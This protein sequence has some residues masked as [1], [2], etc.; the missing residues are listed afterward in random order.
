MKKS[1]LSFMA[2]MFFVVTSSFAELAPQWVIDLHEP[3]T[4]D[5]M[6]YRLL[7]PLDFDSGRLYPVIVS[8]HG[9][10]GVGTENISNLREWNTTLSDPQLRA[11]Y[12]TYVVVPQVTNGLWSK[13]HLQK[14]KTIVAALPSVDMGRIYVLGQS[15]GGYGVNKMIQWDPGYFAAATPVAGSRG[16]GSADLVKNIPIWAFHGTEDTVSSFQ[17]SQDFFDEM[18]AI[19]GNMKFTP[20]IGW[21]HS[22]PDFIPFV[23]G[24]STRAPTYLSSDRCDPEPVYMTWLFN[25]IL[26]GW[27]PLEVNS[28]NGSGSYTNGQQVAISA[29]AV[30]GRTFVQWVGDT[31]VV[32]NVTYTNALVTMSNNAVTLTATYTNLPG[33]SMLTVNGGSGSAAYTNGTEAPITANPAPAG[34][35]FER[36]TGD[37]QVVES[38]TSPSTVVTMPVQDVFLTAVYK[39][40]YR[41]TVNNGSGSGTYTNGQPVEISANPGRTFVAWIGDTQVVSSATASPATVTMP[42]TGVT[43]TATYSDVILT[44]IG[45]A[46]SGAYTS[47]QTV[48]IDASD[49]RPG[50]SFK[51]WIGTGAPYVA[52]V[53]SASTTVT[54]PVQDIT[55]TATHYY[56]L[57]VNSG[58]G[59]GTYTNGQQV[60]I[61]A[62]TIPW[63]AFD[64]WTGD[65][66]VLDEVIY[67]D[68]TVTMSTNPVTLTATYVDSDRLIVLEWNSV[69]NVTAQVDI[70]Q[71]NRVIANGVYNF[72]GIYDGT[73]QAIL[74]PYAG[75]GDY[76]GTALYGV[77]QSDKSAF[78]QWRLQTASPFYEQKPGSGG[79]YSELLYLKAAD[80]LDM[81]T[82][83]YL[84]ELTVNNPA[85]YRAA[86]RDSG[87]GKWYVSDKS[88]TTAAGISI[89]NMAD[90]ANQWRELTITESSLM[91][92]TNNPIV[93]PSFTA[94]NAVGLF[95]DR[96]TLNIRPVLLRVTAVATYTITT[97]T[98]GL[99][100]ISPTSPTVLSGDS[101]AFVISGGT[102]GFR[103]AT[104][105]TN[106][107]DVA[108]LI[109][110]NS[111][112]VVNFT[113]N[114]VTADG[115]LAATF[116]NILSTLTVNNGTGGGGIYTNGQ[117]VVIEAS[118]A[119]AGMV[120]DRWDG[121]GAPYAAS[122]YAPTTTVTMGSQSISLTAMYIIPT[123]ALTVNSGS[124]GGSYTN[125]QQV[126]ISA[127]PVSGNAFVQ[128]IGDTQVVN[129]VTYTNA[130]VTMSTNPVTLTA[131]YTK[132]P[133][134]ATLTINNGTGGGAYTNETQVLITASNAPA[135]QAFD[136]WTGD[137]QVVASVTS[138]S[139]TVTM[140]AQDVSLTATYK[141]VY[142]LTVNGGTGSGVYTNGQLVAVGASDVRPGVSFRE[143]IGTGAP[144]VT[145]TN[146]ASTT[147]I[148][149]PQNITLIA[150]Y[151]YA[152][153]VNSG[154]GSGVYTNGEQVVIT[155]SN[156]PP[157]KVFRWVGD[158][159]VVNKVTYTNALVT[160]STNP[161]TLTATYVD[162]VPAT[163]TVVDSTGGETTSTALPISK[164]FSITGGNVLVV[165]LS[166]KA[167][168]NTYPAGPAD[169]YWVTSGGTVTQT[170]TRAV[171]AGN[172][173]A[174]AFGSSIFYLWNPTAGSGTISGSLPAGYLAQI[175]SA[176]T[177]SGVDTSVL[178]IIASGNAG[179]VLTLSSVTTT[180]VLTGVPNGGFAALC[181]GS[182]ATNSGSGFSASA[183]GGTPVNWLSPYVQGYW[184]QGYISNLVTTTTNFT[185][186]HGS[187]AR[188]HIVAA[189]F[190]PANITSLTPAV[191][192]PTATGITTTNATLGATVIPNGGSTIDDYGIVYAATAVNSAPEAGGPDAI[193][194]Q[195]GTNQTMGVFT[196]KATGLTPGVQ[197]SY[198][199]YAHNSAGYGYSSYGT[200]TAPYLLTVN[201]G[202]GS[203]SYTNGA[204]VAISASNLTGKVF[205]QWTGDTAYL[206][207][208]NSA[209]TTVTMPAQAVVLTATYKDIT[210]TLAVNNGTGGGSYTNGQQVAISADAPAEGQLF[211]HWTGD[212]VYLADSNSA[213]TTV[214]MPAQ[215]ISLTATYKNAAVYYTLT[216]DAGAGGTVSPAI[217]NI[218]AG[219]SAD[220]VVTAS[221]YY[222]IA[223]LA[224]NG[225]AVTGMT[226][227]N[228]STTT[229]FTWSN[230][231]TS[232][233]L[234]VTFTAQVVTNA[235]NV[236]YS[237][238]ARHGLTNSGATFDQAAAVDQD[239]D[240]LTAWQ[241][242]IA[243]TDPTNTTSGFKAAQDNR[244]IISWNSFSGRVYSVYW[245]TNLLNGFQPLETNIPWTQSSFTNATP[246]SRVNH[247]QIKVRMQ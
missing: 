82:A 106:G 169:V 204:H 103:V 135:G 20:F 29:K 34:Q 146:A 235:A 229:N 114:N 193:K 41:L 101:P 186:T 118:N 83:A 157:G 240:G 77:V 125:G 145:S 210:Y 183:S 215:A 23:A 134:W 67:T 196:V 232:G 35:E 142:G 224:T 72:Y 52:N 234:A 42:T 166:Y 88:Y 46:G 57:T 112:R 137:T 187:A 227:D 200:F 213:N 36:W 133:S 86:F 105:K 221:N 27:Y 170:M 212:T 78:Q 173:A 148:M 70:S 19:G 237:W 1:F 201:S 126:A 2:L 32:D 81:T 160:M 127:N 182:A 22:T 208:S 90:P 219:N 16:L 100:T 73:N 4:I 99:G 11:D 68:A 85:T 178:P 80:N 63:K 225:T 61:V 144:Y 33:W 25:Q 64:Q 110:S 198:A 195:K 228:N 220:F 14:I 54:M 161:V 56:D 172:S 203:G 113:W 18:V 153:T 111:D 189:V 231:Q 26:P 49:V 141:D 199:G 95:V 202:S 53:I 151:N 129:N 131:T 163:I 175:I 120:F 238:M 75:P 190:S 31:Q 185:C 154:T 12:P 128:W 241:E 177:L 156:A 188:L 51:D 107:A 89:T 13:E 181:S 223:T 119:P 15:M 132:L 93:T 226:F 207:N 246:D 194:L 205:V 176:F 92:G 44:V 136:R 162:Y 102:N 152:L 130:L 171:Q 230:V 158:T 206:A 98:D 87:T 84:Y 37:T 24:V 94:V 65:T 159:Q 242:Y 60:L 62:N 147:V 3:H 184:Y 6:P 38:V 179:N 17:L 150:T 47:G 167:A 245:S 43:L 138:P 168:N 197:Y 211:D 217:T 218:L 117:Q 222:R 122:I 40:V 96:S 39:D 97:S 10:P 50:V 59:S 180:N 104:L 140:P 7:R 66:Q 5:G 143:W 71:T 124:G 164:V 9:A 74:Y 247:Y 243:G 139:T 116:T 244:N 79:V 30:T 28:G 209:S 239:G 192:V 214:I 45:G 115:T 123:Y 216:A 48:A 21:G 58:T 69:S 233:V 8:L 55:L 91:N 236:P 174:K 165:N 191:Q 108:G 121:T 155:A 149:P 109:F 76:S